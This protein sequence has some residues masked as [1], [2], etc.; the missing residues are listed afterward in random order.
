MSVQAHV[1]PDDTGNESAASDRIVEECSDAGLDR[2]TNAG[3]GG[4]RERVQ[5]GGP[6]VGAR[7]LVAVALD[8][9]PKGRESS[10]DGERRVLLGEVACGARQRFGIARRPICESNRLVEE[11][12]VL[13]R[14]E[15]LAFIARSEPYQI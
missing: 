14:S 10:L 15:P 5:V 3:V 2:G 1:F 6:H 13:C 12:G 8:E 7:D 11:L 9:P 4:G